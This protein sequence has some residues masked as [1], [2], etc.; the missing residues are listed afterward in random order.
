MEPDGFID[1]ILK[2]LTIIGILWGILATWDKGSETLLKVWAW[3]CSVSLSLNK[4]KTTVVNKLMQMIDS[5]EAPPPPQNTV[6][7]PLTGTLRVTGGRLVLK[8][9]FDTVS[10]GGS[11]TT[12]ATLV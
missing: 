12:S 11:A 1:T 5:H 6:I 8:N 4:K 7:V 3:A 2:L 9:V 10:L